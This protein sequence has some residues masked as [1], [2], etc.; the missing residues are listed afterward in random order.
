MSR[1]V[2]ASLWLGLYLFCVTAKD[3]ESADEYEIKAAMLLNITHFVEWPAAKLG[4][5]GAPF[6]IGIVGSDPF[7]KDIDKVVAGKNVSGHAIVIQRFRNAPHAECC[8]LL[9]IAQSERRNLTEITDLLGHAPVLTVGDGEKFASSGATVGFVLRNNRVQIEV[10][11]ESAQR[12]GLT[13][14]SR[15]LRLVTVVKDGA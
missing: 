11:L 3:A 12:H 7:G 5:T 9:F 15:L 13:V 6:V 4:E 14:S 2:R 1:A 10:N 8:Q